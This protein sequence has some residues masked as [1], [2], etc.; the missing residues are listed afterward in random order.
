MIGPSSAGRQNS[1]ADSAAFG[2]CVEHASVKYLQWCADCAQW[3][4][5]KTAHEPNYVYI[6][7][8]TTDSQ[9]ESA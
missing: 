9:A 6:L 8:S 2:S 5:S 7:L 1:G 4:W 3:I